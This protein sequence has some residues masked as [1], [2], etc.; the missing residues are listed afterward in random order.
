MRVWR[1]TEA[2]VTTERSIIMHSVLIFPLPENGHILPTLSVARYLIAKGCDVIYLTAPQF[3]SFIEGA[4]AQLEPLLH[5]NATQQFFSGPHIWEEFAPEKE[6]KERL[7]RLWGNLLNTR[8][9]DLVLLDRLLASKYRGGLTA[10]AGERRTILFSTSLLNWTDDSFDSVDI[11]LMF[12]CP[13]AFEV[14][15]FRRFSP[16]MH[17]VE[18]SLRD[19][20]DASMLESVVDISQPMVLATFGTQSMRYR[21]QRNLLRVIQELAARHPSIQFVA[22]AG[23]EDDPTTD[24][25]PTPLN[26]HFYRSVPQRLLLSRASALITHGG[27]GSIKEAIIAGVPMVVL[28]SLY[29]QPF[30]AMRVRYHRLG[31]AVF[32]ERYSVDALDSAFIPALEG[33]Y[34]ASLA[35][36]RAH[37]VAI[38]NSKLSHLLIGNW[39]ANV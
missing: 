25:S 29:D 24:L 19:M 32:P 8:H 37:F 33:V 11:P 38:E 12:F 17:Y 36:M 16:K 22:S 34:A 18:A 28:P 4:G 31:D 9:F 15:K 30:N 27:L 35:A 5:Q 3:R 14:P 2:I 1:F 6:R 23:E 21:G 20:D 7:V 39:L 13:S 26:F 10:I